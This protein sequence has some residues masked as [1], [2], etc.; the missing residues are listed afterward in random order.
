MNAHP[1]CWHH[2]GAW[3]INYEFVYKTEHLSI[4]FLTG[5][6]LYSPTWG[7][8]AIGVS[9]WRHPAR[10]TDWL[11][12]EGTS[13]TSR[14]SWASRAHYPHLCHVREA[15]LPEHH[16][17]KRGLNIKL[18]NWWLAC[19]RLRSARKMRNKASVSRTRAVSTDKYA[20]GWWPRNAERKRKRV[21]F[22]LLW[23]S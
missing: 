4:S 14:T 13:G 20:A 10:V 2:H 11:L 8:G 7:W 21:S 6:G 5:S 17:R 18:T 16:R 3:M 19:K 12:T 1:I 22:D 23:S 9:L 15:A